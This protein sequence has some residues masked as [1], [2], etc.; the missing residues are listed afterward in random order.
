MTT[1]TRRGFF[2]LLTLPGSSYPLEL[3]LWHDGRLRAVQPVFFGATF[4]LCQH[5]LP[6]RNALLDVHQGALGDLGEEMR[7][8]LIAR[9]DAVLQEGQLALGDVHLAADAAWADCDVHLPLLVPLFVELLHHA[10]GPGSRKGAGLR[11]VGYV[12]TVHEHGERAGAVVVA[13]VREVGPVDCDVV[14]KLREEGRVGRHVR[15][16]DSPDERLPDEPPVLVR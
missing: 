13:P 16:Q 10:P 3:R 11:W 12:G 5:A 9:A 1:P 7:Q 2:P 4:V 6:M 15:V 14:L 8:G